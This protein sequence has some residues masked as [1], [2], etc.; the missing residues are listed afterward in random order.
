MSK[1]TER[2]A[3][4]AMLAQAAIPVTKVAE[5]PRD[6]ALSASFKQLGIDKKRQTVKAKK[7][8]GVKTTNRKQ[9]RRNW[10]AQRRYDEK[11]G[12]SNGYDERIEDALAFRRHEAGEY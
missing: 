1:E 12:T 10:E 11:H 7:P 6:A 2:A 5:A 8:S 3:L 9:P 4:A